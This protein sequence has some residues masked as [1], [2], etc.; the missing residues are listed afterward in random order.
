M[1]PG[2]SRSKIERITLKFKY[3]TDEKNFRAFKVR[4]ANVDADTLLANLEQIRKDGGAPDICKTFELSGPTTFEIWVDTTYSKFQLEE[5]M[6][7]GIK[8]LDQLKIGN[9]R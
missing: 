4:C 8:R 7:A 1:A 3:P 9:A 5:K 6:K 2:T